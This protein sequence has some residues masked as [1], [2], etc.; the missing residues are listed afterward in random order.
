VVASHLAEHVVQMVQLH[1][2]GRSVREAG[3][4][5]GLWLPELNRSEILHTAYNSVQLTGL[6]LLLPTFKGAP[7]RWWTLALVLQGWHWLEHVLLQ[8]QYL[9]GYFVFN[10]MKQ[11]SLLELFFPRSELHFAYNLAVFIPIVVAV[12]LHCRNRIRA[13]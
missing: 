8:V 13:G 4:V 3:G 11:T 12:E 1:A 6:I 5:L 2:L 10:A 9:T 7:R